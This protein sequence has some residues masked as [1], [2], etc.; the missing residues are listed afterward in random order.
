MS[1]LCTAYR[2]TI[3]HLASTS[4]YAYKKLAKEGEAFVEHLREIDE[5]LESLGEP[6]R[7]LLWQSE[8]ARQLCLQLSDAVWV[9]HPAR[10]KSGHISMQVCSYNPPPMMQI[11]E[12]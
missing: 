8:V 4:P 6:A 9:T 3:M 7:H 1:S 10:S 11:L 2:L 12:I 5:L